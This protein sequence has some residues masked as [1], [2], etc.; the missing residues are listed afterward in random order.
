VLLY[1][2]IT[3]TCIATQAQLFTEACHIMLS[4]LSSQSCRFLCCCETW[5]IFPI[6]TNECFH[7]WRPSVLNIQPE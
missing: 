4:I 3:T 1:L 7:R 5:R 2:V 6:S